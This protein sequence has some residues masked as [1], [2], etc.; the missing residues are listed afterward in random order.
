MRSAPPGQD[1]HLGG[2]HVEDHL[3]GDH[4]EC[5]I[6]FDNHDNHDDGDDDDDDDDD[7][8]EKEEG[9]QPSSLR[10]SSQA[11]SYASPKL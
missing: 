10:T 3:G 4:V 5:E 2:D 7:D 6:Y 11:P 1:C 8:D 9:D